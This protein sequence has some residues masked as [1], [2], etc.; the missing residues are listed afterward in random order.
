MPKTAHGENWSHPAHVAI[1]II[2]ACGLLHFTAFLRA[3]PFLAGGESTE[4]ASKRSLFFEEKVRPILDAHCLECHGPEKQKGDLRLDSR[5]AVLKGGD[6]GPAAIPS[7]PEDSRL[8]KA[9]MQT[10]ELKMPNKKPQLTPSQI[11]VLKSWIAAGL[12]WPEYDKQNAASTGESN[13]S[14]DST[15]P[16]LRRKPF[17]ITESDREW[18]SFKA[19]RR[20]TTPPVRESTAVA[21]PIDAFLLARLEPKKLSLSHPASKRELVRRAYFDLIGLPPDTETV[22]AFKRDTSP[23]AWDRLVDDLLSRPQYGE[24]WGRH[25]LDIVRYADTNGYER[26]GAKPHAW[27]YRDYV[28]DSLNLDR[29]YNRFILEQLAGDELGGFD[30]NAI[31][32]TGFYRLHVWDDEPDSTLAAEFDD[33]DDIMVTTSAAFLGLTLGCA[34]CHDHKFDPISQ[35]DYYQFLSFFRSLNPYGLH[36]T[37]GGGR[38]TGIITRP[39]AKQ[40]VV[41]AWEMESAARTKPLRDRLNSETNAEVKAKLEGQIREIEAGIPYGFALAIHED[42]IKPTQIFRRGDIRSPGVEVQPGFPA[43]FGNPPPEVTPCPENGSSGRRL[44]L[45]QWIARPENSLTSRVMMNRLWQHHFGRGLVR[46]PNDF[47]RTGLPPSNPELL[48]FLATEFVAGGWRLK[49]MHKLIMTSNAYRMSSRADNPA[50]MEVDEANDLFWRQNPRRVE[51]EVLRD[52]ML[53]ISGTLSLKMGGPGF[54]PTLPKEVHRTQDG[55]GKGWADS[56]EAE[57]NRRS[58]YLYIKRGLLPP[59]LETFD[60]TATTVPVGERPVTTVAPQALML[61]NDAFA[62]QVAASFAERLIRE[63]GENELA[64]IT[65]AFQLAIQRLPRNEELAASLAMLHDQQR[66]AGGPNASTIALQNFCAALLNLNEFL[67]AD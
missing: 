34:R 48:D 58:A 59:F 1:W 38:G 25:W 14:K 40:D 61:L 5:A 43:I 22:E 9:V 7:H 67:Y 8:I 53:R 49:R 30:N 65:R 66:L 19:I 17:E 18:W 12:A 13:E 54:F 46:T 44:A 50:A 37:G 57:Q 64:Q 4:V 47:G 20:P 16:K 23:D 56:P 21:N 6:N 45:A 28:I 63:A 33:L 27:R 41:K 26:D 15:G 29:P 3:E 62:R 36:K 31:V 35:A 24:R 10:G 42:P 52:S 51:G 11:A 60:Y 39:L 2:F 55:E 32:A